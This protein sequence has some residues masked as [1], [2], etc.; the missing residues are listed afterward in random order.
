MS[1]FEA[2]VSVVTDFLANRAS[3]Q[4]LTSLQEVGVVAGKL[5][6]ERGLRRIDTPVR[7]D[8]IKDV[9]RAIDTRSYAEHAVLMSVLVPHFW[10]NNP[11]ADFWDRAS[12]LGL[13]DGGD[14]ED[15]INDQFAKVVAL[16][17]EVVGVNDNV[18]IPD[19]ASEL[20]DEGTE[21]E[22]PRFKSFAEEKGAA[23]AAA[24]STTEL[25]VVV[26][27]L[28]GAARQLQDY[29]GRHRS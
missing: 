29:V 24:Q 9:L 19:D 16:Y 4:R 3:L 18:V 14:R 23:M 5:L 20:E 17:P 15:F 8:K 28:V 7:R 13:Y 26:D 27:A 22:Y 2:K 25:D 10:D 1:T 21:D 11:G 12:R 6:A